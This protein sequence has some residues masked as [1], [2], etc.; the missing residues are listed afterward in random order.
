MEEQTDPHDVEAWY[1]TNPSMGV[2]LNERKVADEIGTDVIDFN[3]QRLGLWISYNQASAISMKQWERLQVEEVPELEGRLFVGIKYGHD[4]DSV[5]MAIAAR[6]KAGKIFTE[7]IDCRPIAAGDGWILDFLENADI[8]KAVVDGANGQ[9]ILKE[10]IKQRKI[11]APILPT[12]KDIIVSNSTFMKGIFEETIQHTGQPSLVQIV[13][14]CEKRPI[15]TNGGFGFKSILEGVKVELMDSVIL[16]VW[17]CNEH[18]PRKKQKIS[19]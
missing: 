7:V 19:Y 2:I 12:V 3:I 14:N 17:V 1:E 6:T 4:N 11:K 16:A 15:G 18:K 5:S 9:E 8:E 13:T 10:K